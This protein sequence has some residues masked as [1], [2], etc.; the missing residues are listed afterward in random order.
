MP[1]SFELVLVEA[2][3]L[4]GNAAAMS[5]TEDGT[6]DLWRSFIPKL[7]T[8]GHRKDEFL[9]V[10]QEFPSNFFVEFNP[11][12]EYTKWACVRLEEHDQELE[13]LEVPEG[14]YAIFT[15]IGKPS[16][17]GPFF[18]DIF[19]TILPKAG[20]AVDQRPHLAIMGEKYKGENP[21]SE[22]EIW[23]PVKPLQVD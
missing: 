19:S 11:E 15:Y 3:Q 7:E 21:E 14:D 1:M 5:F 10:A 4:Q 13:T 18:Q 12:L 23:I 9:Y 2:F 20:L 17:A 22:E 6:A 16:E 8:L